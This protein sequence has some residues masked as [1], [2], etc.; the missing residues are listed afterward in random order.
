MKALKAA[1]IKKVRDGLGMSQAQFAKTFHL[2]LRSLQEWEQGA[3]TPSGPAAVL[4]WL[5]SRIPQQI[6]KA[7]KEVN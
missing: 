3:M 4:L 1:E 5:V 7:L 2:S 6:I